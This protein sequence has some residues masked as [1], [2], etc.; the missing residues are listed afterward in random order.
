LGFL[1]KE[2][3]LELFLFLGVS[4]LSTV[5]YIRLVR[6]LFF[7]EKFTNVKKF[8]SIEHNNLLLYLIIFL[9]SFNIILIF[10]HNPIYM[11]ILKLIMKGFM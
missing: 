10:F 1:D 4:V 8:E 9:F 5:Y 6:F 2:T 7:I 11:Y 3:Y